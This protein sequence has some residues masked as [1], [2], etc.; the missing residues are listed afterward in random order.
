MVKALSGDTD[1][2]REL[3]DQAFDLMTTLA[4]ETAVCAYGED[5]VRLAEIVVMSALSGDDEAAVE[6]MTGRVEQEVKTA[7]DDGIIAEYG[8]TAWAL[9]KV[10]VDYA[11]NGNQEMLAQILSPR[12]IDLDA[13]KNSFGEKMME[14]AEVLKEEA[15]A[16]ATSRGCKSDGVLEEE[17][18]TSNDETSLVQLSTFVDRA[19]LRV[20]ARMQARREHIRAP[21]LPSAHAPTYD[22]A[23]WKLPAASSKYQP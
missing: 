6:A 15:M 2:L 13:I 23:R 22:P 20:D 16:I 8:K 19:R 12:E 17:E 3:Q 4:R 21:S 7:W 14:A 1:A 5:N 11:Q 10:W 9:M 18:E